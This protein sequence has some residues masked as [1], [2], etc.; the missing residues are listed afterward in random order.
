MVKDTNTREKVTLTK[1]QSK[2]LEEM[3]AEHGMSKSALIGF[4]VT[5]LLSY[6]LGDWLGELMMVKLSDKTEEKPKKTP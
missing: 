4:A 5:A 2:Q 3:A 1:E 6:K